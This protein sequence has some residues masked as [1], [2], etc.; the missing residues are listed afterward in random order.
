MAVKHWKK[1]HL[2]PVGVMLLLVGAVFRLLAMNFAWPLFLVLASQVFLFMAVVWVVLFTVF[3]LLLPLFLVLRN[4]Y[5]LKKTFF[6][7]LIALFGAFQVISVFLPSGAVKDTT[8]SLAFLSFVSSVI[9]IVSVWVTATFTPIVS[10]MRRQTR[11]DDQITFGDVVSSMAMILVPTIAL[12]FFFSP[13]GLQ[14][15]SVTP[16]QIFITSLITDFF[17]LAYVYLFVI[18][19]KVFTW[20]QLGFKKVDREDFGRAF[21][22]FVLVIVLIGILQALLERLGLP[23]QRYTFSNSNGAIF[24]L[25]ITVFVTP[26]V[27]EL[28]FRGFLFKGLL[29]HNRPWV[30]YVVSAGLFAL[31]HPPLLVMVDIFIIGLLLAYLVKQTRSIWPSILIHMLN[32]AVVFGYLLFG[33]KS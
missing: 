21:I 19:P 5:P 31:L 14:G 2:P 29:M 12:S 18:R 11:I 10:T 13:V 7:A 27:E 4:S 6:F 23:L 16:S 32:N 17:I 22:L 33:F 30:A 26:F 25:A 8:T 24:A 20:R 9:W 1:I 3:P 15:R 28:Y